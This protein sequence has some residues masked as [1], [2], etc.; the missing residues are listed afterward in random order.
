MLFVFPTQV[1]Y[2]FTMAP[3]RFAL[4]VI[5]I[6][7]RGEVVEV[8]EK[9]QPGVP[10]LAVSNPY[11]YVLELNAGTVHAHGIRVGDGMRAT[12]IGRP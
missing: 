1:R 12:G 11:K 7:E 2:F 5:L 6:D 9:A 10:N 3:M 8:I 4:D